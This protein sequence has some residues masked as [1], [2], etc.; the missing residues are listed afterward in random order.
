MAFRVVRIHTLCHRVYYEHT[1][2]KEAVKFN[3]IPQ[4]ARRLMTE[5]DHIMTIA[6]KRRANVAY[7]Q[8][9]G[10]E[11]HC[12]LVGFLEETVEVKPPK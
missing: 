9:I 2:R 7:K 11:L 8:S 12:S 6:P 5:Y 1:D 4:W 10:S 3:A